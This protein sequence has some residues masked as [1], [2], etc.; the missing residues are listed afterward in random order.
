MKKLIVNADDF[1]LTA[2]VNRA[3]IDC[4]R[5][6][7]VT[8]AT[9][10][11][12]AR[13]AADAAALFKDNPDLGVGLHVN[14]TSGEPL[15]PPQKVSSLV[16]G[17][18][19]F[20]GVSAA[21]IRLT[22]GLA[23]GAEIEAEIEAQIERCRELG[24]EPTHVDS[25]HHVHAHPRV[26]A[27]LSWVCRRAGIKK[28][29]GYRMKVSSPKSLAVRLA[30]AVPVGGEPLQ[31]PGR[32][33]GIEEMGSR[34]MAAALRRELASTRGSLEFMCHPGYA[35]KDLILA[36]S[37][38]DGRQVELETLLSGEFLEA[39]RDAGAEMISFRDL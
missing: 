34:D 22:A 2:G 19:R 14:L 33:S 25:H 20:P 5:A 13:A 26:R 17:D 12:G 36:S 4:H 1:G 37:Y 3:V 15:L 32:F 8:S 11:V 21:M 16:S 7:V 18:G 23:R 10:M 27:I 28:A 39:A 38:T 24:I 9:L 31:T 29:R 30:A 6:G 35:D